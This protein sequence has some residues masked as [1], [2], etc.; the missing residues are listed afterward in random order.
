MMELRKETILGVIIIELSEIMDVSALNFL[1]KYKGL[2]GKYANYSK[3]Q[4]L[5]EKSE[6]IENWELI[7]RARRLA[8]G[9]LDEEKNDRKQPLCSVFSNLS[10]DGS[11]PT[12]KYYMPS[13]LNMENVIPCSDIK[14]CD[15]SGLIQ[16]FCRELDRLTDSSPKD[17][18]SFLIVFDTLLKK[19]FWSV[20]AS[21]KQDEDV[22]F[23][24]YLKT[25]TAITVALLQGWQNDA[26]YIMVAGHFSGIQNYIFSVSKVG[27][28]GVTKRLRARSFYVNAMISALAHCIIHKFVL[29]MGNILMLTGGKFYLLLPNAEGVETELYRIEEQVTAFLYE[30]FKGNL[31]LELVWKKVTDDE[32]CNY[33]GIITELSQ[34]FAEKK[35]RLLE[36]VLVKEKKWD[37]RQF[38]VYQDLDNKSMCAS[39]KSALVDEGKK[40]CPNCENDTEIGGKLPKIK[41]FSFSRKNGQYKLLDDYYLNLD[42]SAGGEDNYLI[43]QMNDAEI[44]NMYDQPVSVYYAVNHVPTKA[45]NQV[46]TFAEIAEAAV[47]NKKLGILKADVDTLGFLFSDGLKKMDDDTESISRVSTLSRMMELFFGGCL[48]QL[49]E[50]KYQNV[51]CVFS[52]GDDLFFI[53]PWSDMPKLAIEINDMFHAY[54][55]NNRCMTMSTA[56]CI[57]EG[58]GHISTLAEY[59]ED[60]LKQVK[61]SADKIIN[62]EKAGRN[63]VYFLGKIMSWEDFK[64]QVKRSNQF[65]HAVSK[66]GVSM[67]R[68]LGNY[69]RMYQKYLKN[70]EVDELMFLPLFAYDMKRNSGILKKDEWIQGHYK[71]LYRRA[72]GYSKIDKLFYYTE[73]CVDYAFQLTREERKHG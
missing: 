28:G 64:E 5:V 45:G 42:I 55:G 32:I 19:Y 9:S 41:Q 23:Y 72:S 73:F 50:R 53:G 6:P 47:G 63:G 30:K 71:E 13:V 39:C 4:R 26:P 22:S 49:I 62:P 65:A 27:T 21:R 44:H 70:K 68:R 36:S 51:Y 1:E 10:L 34:K 60:K 3:L 52:G 35:K 11:Y 31:S 20:P 40:K 37:I 29:P 38:A 43:M 12:K 24:D 58:G 67:I 48:H 16:E 59:C 8:S 61:Q 18:D 56:I 17:F 7:Q 15:Y 54:T 66:V 2:F 57:A 46:K 33:T 69:S 25:V 14:D